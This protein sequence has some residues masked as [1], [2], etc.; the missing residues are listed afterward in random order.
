ML[1]TA[2][3]VS[4]RVAFEAVLCGILIVMHGCSVL[5]SVFSITERSEMGL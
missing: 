3:R 2:V 1:S 4:R 5:S